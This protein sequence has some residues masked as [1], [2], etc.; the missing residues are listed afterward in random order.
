MAY[1]R[2]DDDLAYGEYHGGGE[3]E[4]GERGIIGDVTK[5]IF[6]RNPQPGQS[7]SI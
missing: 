1:H 2:N 6:G 3:Q 7:V 5:R 4:E